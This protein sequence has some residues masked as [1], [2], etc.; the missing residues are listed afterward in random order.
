MDKPILTIAVPTWNRATILDNALS[1]LLPQINN[2]KNKIEIIISDNASDDNTDEVIK[3]HCKV[4]HSLNIIHNT[5]SENTGY[6]GN[7][8]KCRTLSSG[9]YFWLLSDNDFIANGLVDYLFNILVGQKPSFVFLKDWKHA[10]KVSESL[11]FNSNTYTVF[12]AIEK[13]NYRTTLISAV[14]FKNDK[15]N[16]TELFSHFKG[17]TF[18]GF[19]FF[20]EALNDK[21]DA[22]EIMGPSLFIRDTKVSF[23][24]FKSF[25]VDLIACFEYA[26]KKEILPKKTAQIFINEVIYKLTV[27]HYILYR[28]TGSLHGQTHQK[29]AVHTLLNNGFHSYNAYKEELY[30]LQIAKSFNFYK[31]VL[32]KHLFRI[33]KER[34]FR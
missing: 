25:A 26:V 31:L 6:F 8:Y 22:V 7:F 2:N 23:N 14:I 11:G 17:N 20:L 4:N 33:I 10:N 28:I 30:P 1:A 9:T 13:F 29:E 18:L 21:S 3:K 34:I 5:Q 12:K 15:R 27:K 16:D 32:S 19:S 24:A